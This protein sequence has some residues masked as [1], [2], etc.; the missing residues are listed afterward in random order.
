M[1][2][3]AKN[4]DLN[5]YQINNQFV[6]SQLPKWMIY[7]SKSTNHCDCGTVLGSTYHSSEI[8][9]NVSHKEIKKLERKGWSQAKIKR[10]IEE[11]EKY[12]DKLKRESITYEERYAPQAN[13]WYEFIK[14]VVLNKNLGTFGL[15]L[16]MY[17]TSPETEMVKLKRIENVAINDIRHDFLMKIREDVLYQFNQ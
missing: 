1:N 11:K 6:E 4:F 2:E 8:E 14:S 7:L 17:R 12:K 5:F 3:I 10:W 15:L 13:E 16:H 9:F